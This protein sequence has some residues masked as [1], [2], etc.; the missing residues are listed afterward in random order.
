MKYA[1]Q[2]ENL[3]WK[4]IDVPENDPLVS[5][6]SWYKLIEHEEPHDSWSWSSSWE[7]VIE[8]HPQHNLKQLH[9][10]HRIRPNGASTAEDAL[11]QLI[12]EV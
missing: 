6:G 7:S 5:D 10:F 1:Q 3:D 4:V 11:P 12:T 9:A 2:Q 8:L